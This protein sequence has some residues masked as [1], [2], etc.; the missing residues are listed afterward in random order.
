VQLGL[1][2]SAD[3]PDFTKERE[4]ARRLPAEVHLGTSSWTFPGWE[5]IL[6]P[7]GTTLAQLRKRGLQ[8]YSANPLL[9]T[10]GIDSSYYRPLSS[11]T[12]TRYAEQ[13]PNG[14]RCVSKV[15]REVTA[16]C[17]P[18]T[19]ELNPHFLQPRFFEAQVLRPIA[20]AF[21]PHQ[22]PL[23]LQFPELR[24]APPMRAADFAA[25]LSRFLGSV[26]REFQYAIELR[27][28]LLLGPAYVEVLQRH[29]AAHVFNYWERMP[30]LD[31]QR[32]Q[33]DIDA[34]AFGVVRLLIPPSLRYAE[35]KQQLEPFNRIAAVQQEMRD[36]TVALIEAFVLRG[37][38]L[39]VL[40]N[41]KAE[42]CSPLTLRGIA[43]QWTTRHAAGD[44]SPP[45]SL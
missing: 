9:R 38:P 35:R 5:T 36:Q 12:L 2:G 24:H 22:G 31:E 19:L 26:S 21:A 28:R 32:Q 7:T 27:D 3:T 11:A 1:F 15:P 14:F 13:L 42:G 16:R 8:L 23:V 41:N 44:P 10:V 33:V 17:D 37:R 18:Q 25:Q 6:Y 20:D 4:L 34:A 45:P 30:A 39:F 43:E 29:Q 40:A